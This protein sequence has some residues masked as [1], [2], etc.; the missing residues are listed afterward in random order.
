MLAH[1]L[2]E[3]GLGT[4][5]KTVTRWE[6]GVVP[7]DAAQAALC[8]LFSLPPETYLR[9]TWPGWLPT[10]GLVGIQEPWNA[11][12]T[13][14][15][16]TTVAEHAIVDRREFVLLMGAELLLPIYNWRLN[17]GPWLAYRDRGHQVSNALVDEIERLISVRRRMDDEH[18]GGGILEMLH[19]DLRFV[20][21]M[22]KNG[23]YTEATG[24]RLYG[25]T[26]E[27]ARLAGWA[28]FDSGRQAAAQQ[29]YFAALRAAAAV[30]DHPLAVNV[31]GF[32]GI[33]AY[34]T[35]RLDDAT[36][37]L[38]VATAESQKKTPSVI[39]AMTWARAGR[40]YA[41]VGQAA[42]A[43]QALTKSTNLLN[44]AVYGDSPNWAYWVDETRMAAQLGRALFDLGDYAGASR[45]L[46]SAV[47]SCGTKYPRDRATWL[48]RVAIA[49]LR[50][51]DIDAGCES[52]RQT[53]DLI[54]NQ[55][56]SERGMGFLRTFQTELAS[57]GNSAS[58]REF[59][60]YADSRL[61]AA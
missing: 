32:L 56:D 15:A 61:G 19:S 37:L 21:D 36:Q 29:Y 34:S 52:G 46:T 26:A 57:A 3:Q 10:S 35:G 12:G 24:Q 42:M 58:A 31:V 8:K 55:I 1:L 28:A 60:E 51:G 22:L 20:T 59:A 4:T 47:E 25:A 18:G 48:G 44:R 14:N 49:H 39:Q 17:P 50:T 2:R 38:E 6:H 11:E 27:L 30:G 16:L 7:D 54:A 40:A 9:V 43:R 41:K 5:R 45:E 23:R 53:V 13:I 33:Q